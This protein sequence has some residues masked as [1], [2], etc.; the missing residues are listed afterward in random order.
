MKNVT[1]E[2][3]KDRFLSLKFGVKFSTYTPEFTVAKSF[4]LVIGDRKVEWMNVL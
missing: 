4:R 1:A 2:Q 3:V